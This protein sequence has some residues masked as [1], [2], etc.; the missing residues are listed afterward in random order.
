MTTVSILA[1]AGLSECARAPECAQDLDV[2]MTIFFGIFFG[3]PVLLM[4]AVI[5]FFLVRILPRRR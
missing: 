3:V 5:V 1:E 2:G 4:V